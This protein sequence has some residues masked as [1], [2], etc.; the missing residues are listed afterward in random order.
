MVALW[1]CASATEPVLTAS[2]A[3]TSASA[4][5]SACQHVPVPSPSLPVF[6]LLDLTTTHELLL[7]LRTRTHSSLLFSSK[8]SSLIFCFTLYG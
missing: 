7:A 6:S 3:S 2:G 5:A 4:S 8:P 1:L